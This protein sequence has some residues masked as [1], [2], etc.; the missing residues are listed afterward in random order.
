MT[1]ILPPT[2]KID[3]AYKE[4]LYQAGGVSTKINQY[5]KGISRRVH[6]TLFVLLSA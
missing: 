4:S 5:P 1:G 6:R 3:L 2:A